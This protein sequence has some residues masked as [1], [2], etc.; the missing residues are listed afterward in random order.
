MQTLLDLLLA[1]GQKLTSACTVIGVPTLLDL[2]LQAFTF[3]LEEF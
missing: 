1:T 2:Q 3:A